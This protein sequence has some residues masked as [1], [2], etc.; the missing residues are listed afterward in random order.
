MLSNKINTNLIFNYLSG[1]ILIIFLSSC[2]SLNSL[3]FW[4]DS[5][6]NPDAPMKLE[7]FNVLKKIN[8]NWKMSFPGDNSLGNFIP[9]FSSSNIYFA[10]SDGNIKSIDSSTGKTV[11]DKEFLALSSGVASGF[12]IVII[13][14]ND[15]NVI[16]LNQDTGEKIWTVNVKG[17]VLAPAAVNAELVIVKTGSGELIAL[18]K[19]DGEIAWS[20]R[21]KLPA[22]TIRGSSSPVIDGDQVY[23]TF[24]NG[25]LGVFQLDTGFPL[26]DGAIS[27]VRGSSELEN[28]IDSDSS[29]L[30]DGGYVYTT[31]YQGNM[32]IFDIAQR[33]SVWQSE[34]SSFY[35]PVI[36]KGMIVLVESNSGLRSFFAKNLN[37]SWS[38]EAYL[39]RSLS[40]PINFEG[41]IVLG[42]FEGYIHVVDP[43]NGITIARKKIS[44]KPI[45]TI[46]SRSKNFYVVDEAFNL[47]SLSL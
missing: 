8:I 20:Y 5:E 37:Q 33:R 10:S 25:R 32:N 14:D 1:F 18:D 41:Y 30:I 21:S 17:E 47:F 43:L 35:S 45:K 34:T 27:Y 4:G 26:W 19:L 7:D 6:D 40:N 16:A 24:D 2:S 9:S 36:T 22:L 23:V 15:G 28:L 12:G 29:P 3:K 11:W 39:N 46:I 31:N 38:S 13:A 42:D 44:K